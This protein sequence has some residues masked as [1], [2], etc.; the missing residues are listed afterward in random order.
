MTAQSEV[1]ILGVTFRSDASTEFEDG[2][3][4]ADVFFGRLNDGDL[5][6]VEDEM[7]VGQMTGDGTAE[8]MEF[9]D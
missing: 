8:E 1:T 9:E 4:N 5:V 7:E 2:T 3:L 6:E